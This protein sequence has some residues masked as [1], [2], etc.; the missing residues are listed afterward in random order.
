MHLAF[1]W[2][3][4]FQAFIHLKISF[5]L[6]WSKMKKYFVCK[7]FQIY[8]GLEARTIC[9]V[10][11]EKIYTRKERLNR[12]KVSVI[13]FSLLQI[14]KFLAFR[15]LHKLQGRDWFL[16]S[17]TSIID[18]LGAKSFQWFRCINFTVK[19]MQYSL[20]TSIFL[21]LSGIHLNIYFSFKFSA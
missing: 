2:L 11:W 12:K 15:N 6:S 17:S 5:A 4:K 20:Y 16:Y 3:V 10:T 21:T 8:G 1:C 19:Y 14:M 18:F 9:V 7:S 13:L